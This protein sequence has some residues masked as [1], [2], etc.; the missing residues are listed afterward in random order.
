MGRKDWPFWI[1]GGILIFPILILLILILGLIN[2]L[3]YGGCSFTCPENVGAICPKSPTIC[4]QSSLGNV[5]NVLSLPLTI[6]LNKDSFLFSPFSGIYNFNFFFN[7]II[8]F[9]IGAVI[10]LIFEKIKKK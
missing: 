9:I 10:G 3:F 5:I 6:L 2:I 4:F 7:I 1:K 8:W